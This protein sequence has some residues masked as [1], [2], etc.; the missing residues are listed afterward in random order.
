MKSS[1]QRLKDKLEEET[2]WHNQTREAY[3]KLYRGIWEAKKE[4]GVEMGR[5]PFNDLSGNEITYKVHTVD[6][7]KTIIEGLPL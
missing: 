4:I 3:R 5:S 6:S 2:R 7:L 1:Y